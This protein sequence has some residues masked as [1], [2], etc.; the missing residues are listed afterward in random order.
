MD[1][2]EEPMEALDDVVQKKG[3]GEETDFN[4][5]VLST[6]SEP[7]LHPVGWQMNGEASFG[8][9]M[10]PLKLTKTEVVVLRRA[11]EMLMAALG[12]DREAVGDALYG[13]LTGA[14]L[15]LKSSFTTP[16]A[17]VSMRM[18]NGFRLLCEKCESPEE[19]QT[20]VESLAFKHLQM[21]VTW[22]RGESVSDAVLELMEQNVPDL[23]PGSV[24]AWQ[25]LLRYTSSTFKYVNSSYSERLKLIAND[26]EA[27]ELAA[28][29]EDDELVVRSF[30]NMCAFSV[31]VMG[32][33]TQTWMEELLQVFKVLVEKIA[34]PSQLTEECDL[35]AISIVGSSK[36]QEDI[37]FDNFKPVMMAALRSLL[38][39]DWST[40]HETAWEWL[41]TTVARNLREAT[42]KVRAFRPLNAQLFSSLQEE[43]L[44]IFRSTI[45]TD[46]FTKCAASQDLFKQSQS[47]LRYI[48]DKVLQSSYD[49]FHRDKNDMVDYLSALGLRHV[50]YGVPID[51]FGPFCD[52][53]LQVM[54]PLID[55]LPKPESTKLVWCP[56]DRAHQLAERDVPMHLMVEGFRWSL[57][58]VSRVLMR[59]IVEGSTSVMQAIHADDANAMRK[60]LLDAPRAERYTWQLGVRV[61]SQSISPLYW[62]L[63]TG[64][65]Q[66]AST[67]LKDILTI[68]ADRDRYYYGVNELFHLQPNIV[69]HI[70]HEAPG[71]A[72][73]FLDGL[74]WR[75]HKTSQGMR[76]VIY[77]LEHL[78]KDMDESEKLSRALT[79]F[80]KFKHPG[81]I[82][83]PILTFTLDLLWQRLVMGYFLSGQLMTVFNF[84]I[85]I[86][87]NCYLNN[88]SKETPVTTKLLLVAR[89]WVYIFG[90]GRR[91]WWHA[92]QMYKAFANNDVRRCRKFL[93][94]IGV[95]FI[96]PKYLGHGTEMTGL[97]L[98][99]DMLG[100]LAL[101]PMIHCISAEEI[102]QFH[103]EAWTEPMSF[104][105]GV[106][107]VL[108]I[109]LYLVLVLE[110]GHVS[111]EL[112]QYRVL[113]MRAA[114]QIL[115]CLG[116][117]SVVIISFTLAITALIYTVPQPGSRDDDHDPHH[118]WAHEW[119]DMGTICNTL[120]QMTLGVMDL[121]EIH[122]MADDNPFLFVI[123]AIFMLLVYT[124]FFNL[125]VS[126]FCGVQ[127]SLASDVTGYARLARGDIIV[128]VLK[129]VNMARW[130][131]FISSLELEK[132]IDFEVGDLGLA[133]GIKTEEPALDH[134][135]T[136]DPIRRFG[137]QTDPSLPWPEKL[138]KENGMERFISGRRP[139][140][141][142]DAEN[143]QNAEEVQDEHADEDAYDEEG[144]YEEGEEEEPLEVDQ[145][146][147]EETEPPR[148]VV[149]VSAPVTNGEAGVG[150]SG[151][152]EKS[153]N[154]DET[155]K[156]KPQQER[157]SDNQRSGTK[158]TAETRQEKA[159]RTDR[160]TNDENAAKQEHK[161]PVQAGK[162]P[163]EGK[164]EKEKTGT[165]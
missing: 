97:L 48:A 67:M 164:D 75:S 30:P 49:M 116:V 113:C 31:Q 3:S 134:P 46:F 5:E 71:L 125:L 8:K 118:E 107:L 54:K 32:Q 9:S 110:L 57:G 146:V 19:L 109:F 101:E 154:K 78:M 37:N 112:S 135:V 80:V 136:T 148:G 14:L 129:E 152:G 96:I 126:Q 161:E 159:E 18:F 74:I 89:L 127:A 45:Y 158:E 137:G 117:V 143:I 157:T 111:I 47:R 102:L 83:H 29:E 63:Q 153:G 77:Y 41:W 144:A 16:Q 1:E 34:S 64:A 104:A 33:E 90:M 7:D 140:S 24:A 162:E 142:I 26:W 114:K 163:L 81:I 61:G 91:L 139:G 27:I 2:S 51:L 128:G 4:T 56:A 25:Q 6:D 123:V 62:A 124:F 130:Q 122:G 65:H 38:P 115:L 58:L 10:E 103:C 72:E 22:Q 132:R 44:E 86:L 23:P 60:A 28:N 99:A 13:V 40:A 138:T 147:P 43:Q 145:E 82:T 121:S 108:G 39:K 100:M 131:S 36:T 105:Y 17:V 55:E 59:T 69:E 12:H 133:G 87:A 120:L 85:F 11:F 50:G 79:S 165:Y 84:I 70:L 150:Q 141:V 98:T 151:N 15:T 76:P 20:H 160:K 68:R 92:L 155:A 52:S 106:L 53:C 156:S 93:G 149:A 119:S 42:M 95:G 21:E 94:P 66:T 88:P 35:L 73:T